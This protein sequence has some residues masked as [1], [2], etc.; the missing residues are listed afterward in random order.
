VLVSDGLS[1][2]NGGVL[3]LTNNVMVPKGG[4]LSAT[5]GLTIT[6]MANN[7]MGGILSSWAAHEPAASVGSIQNDYG[8]AIYSTFFGQAATSDD[9]RAEMN[10]DVP[11]C[12][13]PESDVPEA[14]PGIGSVKSQAL[15]PGTLPPGTL[16]GLEPPGPR[17]ESRLRPEGH[18]G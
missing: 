14:W 6:G 11:V 4:S 9:G 16:R 15:T 3:D 7:W 1:V 13:P 2:S 10:P 5:R 18:L 12:Y 8:G 17:E